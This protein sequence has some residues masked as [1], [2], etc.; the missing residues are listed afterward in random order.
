MMSSDPA[1]ATLAA[2]VPPPANPVSNK[3]DWGAI[4]ARLNITLPDDY[5]QV[6]QQYGAGSV[7]PA[8]LWLMNP[9]YGSFDVADLAR[10]LEQPQSNGVELPF[11]PYDC[12][13]GLLPW[14]RTGDGEWFA[15][16]IRKEADQWDTVVLYDGCFSFVILEKKSVAQCL[17]ELFDGTSPLFANVLSRKRYASP[18]IFKPATV[19]SRPTE[20]RTVQQLGRDDLRVCYQIDS[21]VSICIPQTWNPH[22]VA[23]ATAQGGQHGAFAPYFRA[24]SPSSDPSRESIS[25]ILSCNSK[26]DLA[27]PR[28]MRDE[29]RV[30]LASNW[31]EYQEAT[32]KTWQEWGA[33]VGTDA[34]ELAEDDLSG[35]GM[36]RFEIAGQGDLVDELAIPWLIYSIYCNDWVVTYWWNHN[37]EW[38]LE[39]FL[40]Q[41]HPDLWKE[42]LDDI[43]RSVRFLT[44]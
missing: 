32:R 20:F 17:A 40:H 31:T 10:E 11:A 25:A 44:S 19:V 37:G 22:P 30:A 7:E 23:I 16:N 34:S 43:A 2:T 35:S 24:A 12:V 6:I 27:D 36:R 28:Q 5:K 18:Q 21:A 1:L 13:G 39:F 42:S 38:R 41:V 8:T 9:F 29:L 14:G 15:W 33:T 26:S 4:E 3:G